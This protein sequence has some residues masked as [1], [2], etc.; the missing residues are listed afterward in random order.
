MDEHQGQIINPYKA[1]PVVSGNEFFG[2]DDIFQWIRQTLVTSQQRLVVVHGQRRIGKSS[3][4]KE[5]PVRLKEEGFVIVPFD[6]QFHAGRPLSRV[7]HALADAISIQF[8]LSRPKYEDFEKYEF[9]FEKTFLPKIKSYLKPEER[10]LILIDEFDIMKDREQGRVPVASPEFAFVLQ[11][12]ITSQRPLSFVLIAGSNLPKLP[13]YM[14]AVFKLGP[15]VKVAFLSRNETRRLIEA[16]VLAQNML[17]Y[18]DAAVDRIFSLTCG[19]PFATQLLCSEIFSQVIF[20]ENNESGR[21]V[22]S[23]TVDAAVQRALISG[24]GAFSWIWNELSLAERVYL[25][26]IA[27]TVSR[28]RREKVSAAEI[29]MTLA[30]YNIQLVGVDLP[31]AANDLVTREFVERIGS[32]HY[33]FTVELFRRWVVKEYSLDNIKQDIENINPIAR[34]EFELGREAH[35]SG[36]LPRAIKHYQKAA[37]LNRNHARAQIGLAQALLENEEWARAVDEFEKARMLDEANASQG[38]WKRS[39]VMAKNWKRQA[40]KRRHW[41]LT[42]RLSTTPPAIALFRSG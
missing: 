32:S 29:K 18:T 3:I 42:G 41:K 5:L 15:A 12:L 21:T 40:E 8:A 33:R 27:V 13:E 38:W 28:Q 20:S 11:G 17:T 30:D 4:L 37:R 16:P 9:Y 10:L 1:G 22:E 31:E 2:R 36:D 24:T 19:H 39:Q 23:N 26:A 6:L 7:L 34:R 35:L 25:S 14:Q